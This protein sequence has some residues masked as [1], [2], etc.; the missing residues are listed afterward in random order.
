MALMKHDYSGC[1]KKG[2]VLNF[3]CRTISSTMIVHLQ[4]SRTHTFNIGH[5]KFS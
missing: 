2:V 4:E 5:S 1:R 3:F